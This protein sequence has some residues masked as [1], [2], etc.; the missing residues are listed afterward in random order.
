MK[1]RTESRDRNIEAFGE[2]AEKTV[3]RA[4]TA[5]SSSP[6]ERMKERLSSGR[7]FNILNILGTDSTKALIDYAAEQ[8]GVRAQDIV[9]RYLILTLEEKYGEE[10]P[11][12]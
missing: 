4:V 11:A 10:V 8:E 3:T 6:Q 9:R 2:Q 5:D 1:D 7:R 12:S